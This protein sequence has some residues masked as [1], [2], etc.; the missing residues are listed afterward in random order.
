MEARP[1][2]NLKINDKNYYA[3]YWDERG[4]NKT[5]FKQGFYVEKEDAIEFLE[6]KLSI[7]SFNCVFF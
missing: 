2:G 1:D 3:L 5:D 6:E 4:L 7:I